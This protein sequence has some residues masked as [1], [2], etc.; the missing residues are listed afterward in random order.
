MAYVMPVPMTADQN[1]KAVGARVPPSFLAKCCF[2]SC[3]I[4][5]YETGDPLDGCC[6]GKALLA[7]ILEILCMA[8]CIVSLCMWQPD[9]QNIKGDGTQRTVNSKCVA[10]C[11][12]GFVAIAFWESGDFCCTPDGR[13]TWMEG[14]SM[15]GCLLH[16]IPPWV[17]FPP[18][19]GCFVCCCWK[20]DPGNFKRSTLNHGGGASL[21][22]APV[23]MSGPFIRLNQVQLGSAW[24]AQPAV[25]GQPA[26][27]QPVAVATVVGTVDR[28][29]GASSNNYE[30]PK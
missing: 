18:C 4:S 2:P 20:P 9:P 27:Q 22:G 11:C 8:G 10:G 1:G 3:A 28:T 6:Q 17:G 16:C 21:T 12:L 25:V 5:G 23:Q 14:D 15:I 7:L 26:A 24:G 29:V 13:C 30:T 19:D